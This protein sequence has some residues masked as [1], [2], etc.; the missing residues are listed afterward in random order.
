M[1]IRLIHAQTQIAPLLINDIETG[2]PN[3]PFDDYYKQPVYVT[4]NRQFFG[5]DGLVGVDTTQPGYIDLVP[6]DD[7]LLSVE[8]G[9]IAGLVD[10]GLV[11][12]VNIATG[13]LNAPSITT[14]EQDT[15]V[16]T[17]GTN[18][19][20]V[21]ITGTNFLST[22]PDEST[23]LVTATD[24]S[25]ILLTASDI[26]GGG[27]TFTN[28]SIVI[29]QLVHGFPNDESNNVASVTV[30]AERVLTD[31]ETITEI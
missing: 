17:D 20:R 3:R 29:P 6:T 15:V 18:D 19:Y 26:T 4:Y 27:G 16:A 30:T 14:A 22:S 8:D 24:A 21:E 5:N 12:L 31:T 2:S 23:V 28:T 13:A 25:D 1:L 7:V 11:T 9:V 10:Q